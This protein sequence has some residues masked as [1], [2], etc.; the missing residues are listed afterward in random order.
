MKIKFHLII[1][2]NL[3]FLIPFKLPAKKY[4]PP[5][6]RILFVF[7]GSQS[8]LGNWESDK[9]I[10]I[11]RNLLYEMIDS[12]NQLSN[13]ELAMRVYGHQSYVPPQDCND[14]KLEVPFRK[15]NAESIK[16]VLKYIN[17]KGTTPIAYSLEQSRFDFTACNDCRNIIILITD[18]IEA[19]DGDPC[20]VS[21]KLQK[22]GIL[23]KPFIIGIGFDPGLKESF[24][25]VGNFYNATNEK[26]FKEVL[27]IVITK[28][29]NETTAQINLLD[30]LGNPTETDV[31]MI[32]YDKISEKIKYNLIHTI[33]N[34]GNPDTLVLDPLITYRVKIN[35]IP[36][37]YIDSMKLTPGKHLKFYAKTPQGFLKFTTK[38]IKYLDLKIAIREA[39]KKGTLTYMNVNDLEKLIIGN[40]DIEI[41]TLPIIKLKNIGIHQSKT[42]TV[43]IPRPGIV[44]LLFS[45]PGYGSV[46]K[47][48]DNEQEWVCNI[49]EKQDRETILLLPGSYKAVFRPKNASNS[50]FSI[51]RIFNVKSGSSVPVKF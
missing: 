4:E 37:A 10:N 11:A 1:I 14:T 49:N 34:M 7:D 42:T 25:C 38:E 8:M 24:K 28:A 20:E 32:F 50:Y 30:S 46:Y 5:T 12:L 15:N 13:V 18:G 48:I 44:T 26:E 43:E 9:K 29:L 47:L 22:Q 40:Y 23:L 35:T 33:N 27:N 36:P 39:G 16:H 51:T 31:N 45:A 41:P 21:K 6:T 19:C 2:L 3:I 17:P